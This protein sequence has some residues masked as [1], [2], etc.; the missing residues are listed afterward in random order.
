VEYQGPAAPLTR[1][2]LAEDLFLLLA[3]LT[4][5]PPSR[6]ALRRLEHAA[7]EACLDSSASPPMRPGGRGRA[8]P[9]RVIARQVGRAPYRREEIARA[10]TE[11]IARRR[12]GPW[13]LA[14]EGGT[15]F[16]V[17]AWPGEALLAIRLSDRGT[18]HREYKR[19]HLPASLRPSAAAA[20]VHLTRPADDDVFLDPM[21]GAGTLLIERAEAGR[22]SLLLGG[23]SDQEAIAAARANVGRRYQPIEIHRWDACDLPLDAASVTALAVNLPF[24]T[25]I[26]DLET[27]RRLYA[28]FLR[29][30]AR[31]LRRGS[32]AVTLTGDTTTLDAALRHQDAFLRRERYPVQV[33]GHRARIDV[34]QRR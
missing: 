8:R 32:R 13:Q 17:T 21:C 26:G 29:E 4:D 23:D 18:R 31:V 20:L 15:E 12:D 16:W 25:R 9:F 7:R 22:Y 6:E 1:L 30:A 5:L 33:L 28:P 3:R 11:G 19:A 34:L 10:V 27:N 24:G 14:P 2:R